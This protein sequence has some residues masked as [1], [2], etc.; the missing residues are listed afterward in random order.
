MKKTG[1]KIASSREGMSMWVWGHEGMMSNELLTRAYCRKD[2]KKI[3]AESSLVWS[4][5]SSSSL[6]S[7]P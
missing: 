5:S 6:S 3:F 1:R 7:I 4:S 2:W